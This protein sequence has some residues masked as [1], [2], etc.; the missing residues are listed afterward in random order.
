MSASSKPA[1][2]QQSEQQVWWRKRERPSR[3]AVSQAPFLAVRA[4][5]LLAALASLSIC[6]MSRLLAQGAPEIVWEA[7]TP[8]TLANHIVGVGWAPASSQVAMGSSDRW[9]RTRQADNG[10]LIYSILGPQ[11][12]SGADQTVYSS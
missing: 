8:N 11:H 2:V 3:T 9:L 5:S 4:I 1:A 7:P 10:A 6:S 12:S